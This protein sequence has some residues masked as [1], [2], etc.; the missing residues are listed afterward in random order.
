M[1]NV[2]TAPSA[3]L[4]IESENTSGQGKGAIIPEGVKGWSWGP[5]LLN[6]IWAIRKETYKIKCS[7]K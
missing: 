5:F 6:W 1:N 2:Y 7:I 3:S 4:E